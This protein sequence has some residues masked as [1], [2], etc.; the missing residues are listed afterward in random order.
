MNPYESN[1]SLIDTIW[2]PSGL[3]GSE[4][5]IILRE[6]REPIHQEQHQKPKEEEELLIEESE[7]KKKTYYDVIITVVIIA[8]FF[9]IWWLSTL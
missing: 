8:T 6:P 4:L 9:L 2:I 3:P 7:E 1:T 5:N